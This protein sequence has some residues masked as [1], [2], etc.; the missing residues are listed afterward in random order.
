MI[1][2]YIYYYY[3]LYTTNIVLYLCVRRG[4][5]RVLCFSIIVSYLIYFFYKG[6]YFIFTIYINIYIHI[7]SHSINHL[8]CDIYIHCSQSQN[9]YYTGIF[10]CMEEVNFN[11]L[12]TNSHI[13]FFFFI[14]III[15]IIVIFLI[16]WYAIFFS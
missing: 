1:V 9:L 14:N 5:K 2:Y 13:L 11:F 3:F 4:K 16:S 7:S 10:K 12:H 15:G 6:E 8:S